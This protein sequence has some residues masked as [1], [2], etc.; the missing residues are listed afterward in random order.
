MPMEHHANGEV[1]L[2]SGDDKLAVLPAGNGG[3]LLK[4]LSYSH[5]EGAIV[6]ALCEISP[7]VDM[8]LGAY[9]ESGTETDTRQ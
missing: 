9:L 7:Q 3:R 1:S 6:L 2:R 5:A 4:R 8:V